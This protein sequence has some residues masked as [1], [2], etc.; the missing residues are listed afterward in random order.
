M[1][2]LLRFFGYPLTGFFH[3]PPVSWEAGSVVENPGVPLTSGKPFEGK[4]QVDHDG[5]K[6]DG[7]LRCQVLWLPAEIP[8]FLQ[9]AAR[10]E[11][12][13]KQKANWLKKTHQT[14]QRFNFLVK[15]GYFV[16]ARE[17]TGGMYLGKTSSVKISGRMITKDLPC[18]SQEIISDNEGSDRISISL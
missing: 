18:G 17:S 13:A 1:K 10:C 7:K 4:D 6:N 9:G 15:E 12:F 3:S 11:Q 8:W 16:L 2:V 14:Y 5:T